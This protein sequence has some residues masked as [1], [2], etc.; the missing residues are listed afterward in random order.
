VYKRQIYIYIYIYFKITHIRAGFY[1]LKQ[2]HFIGTLKVIH[3][4]VWKF[5]QCEEFKEKNYPHSH[6]VIF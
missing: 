6:Y 1:V 5:G 4:P 3:A 2:F